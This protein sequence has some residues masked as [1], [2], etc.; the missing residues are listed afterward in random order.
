MIGTCR[1]RDGRRC[2][3]PSFVGD[4]SSKG[5]VCAWHA[6]AVSTSRCFGL[7]SDRGT[8]E[9]D[10]LEKRPRSAANLFGSRSVAESGVESSTGKKTG[11]GLLLPSDTGGGSPSR[12]LRRLNGS[13]AVSKH[14][15]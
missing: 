2:G 1:G 10:L 6:R 8:I 11:E 3:E 14:E 5:S 4:L 12:T 9:E 15:I 7:G 13:M